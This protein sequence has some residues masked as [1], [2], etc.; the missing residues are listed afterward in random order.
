[1]RYKCV[2]FNRKSSPNLLEDDVNEFLKNNDIE[3]IHYKQTST[4]RI[5]T[6][7]TISIIYQDSVKL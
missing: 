1:M 4:G 3:I 2:I 5:D 6:T 7:V